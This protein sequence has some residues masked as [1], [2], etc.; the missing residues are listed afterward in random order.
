M[1]ETCAPRFLTG[2]ILN[3]PSTA[4]IFPR[5]GPLGISNPSQGAAVHPES[6]FDDSGAGDAGKRAV[7]FC[8]W[9]RP[10]R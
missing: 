8:C 7:R 2:G 1:D 10:V 3:S 4:R 9:R 6:L 5:R